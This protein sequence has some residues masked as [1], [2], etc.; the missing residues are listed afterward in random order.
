MQALEEFAA[1]TSD[2]FGI[3]CRFECPSP[4]LVVDNWAANNLYN[5]ARE[6]TSNAIKH[7][8]AG[9]V[10]ISLEAR[11]DGALLTVQDDGKGFSAHPEKRD[12]MGLG[13]MKQRAQLIGGTLEIRTN[14]PTGT[15]VTCTL[16]EPPVV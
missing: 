3:C 4:V 13:I 16:P 8:E 12:G 11:S 2:L 14:A 1:S 15:I 5:V 10:T 9:S 6:A 7:G